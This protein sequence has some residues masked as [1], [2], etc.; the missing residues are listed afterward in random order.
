MRARSALSTERDA[1]SE[2]FKLCRQ[3]N[4]PEPRRYMPRSRGV[5]MICSKVASV[6]R[7]MIGRI[8]FGLSLSCCVLFQST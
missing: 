3:M 5:P 4:C 2:D 1:L 6:G 8:G 7:G